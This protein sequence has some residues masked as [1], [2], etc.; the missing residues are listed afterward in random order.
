MKFF[1]DFVAEVLSSASLCN[2]RRLRNRFYFHLSA[3][4]FFYFF[5]LSFFFHFFSQ[6]LWSNHFFTL[7]F[8]IVSSSSS[9]AA[10]APVIVFLFEFSLLCLA[11]RVAHVFVLEFFF[12]CFLSILVLMNHFFIVNNFPLIK[13]WRSSSIDVCATVFF[14]YLLLLFCSVGVFVF[15]LPLLYTCRIQCY[16]V[17]SFS[18]SLA[19]LYGFCVNDEQIDRW[20]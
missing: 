17:C 10:P 7:C 14:F 15:G 3:Q 2:V 12:C 8:I 19:C 6:T 1:V 9:S 18:C 5:V 13:T 20:I 16:I 11:F 4:D